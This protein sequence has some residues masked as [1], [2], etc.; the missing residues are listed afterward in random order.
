MADT[1]T[2][3]THI[4]GQAVIEGVM[5]RNKTNYTIAVRKPDGEIVVVTKQINS[6]A[7]RSKF[8]WVGETRTFIGSQV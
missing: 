5:I 6:P 4:G 1:K 3:K 7:Q 8:L 2:K